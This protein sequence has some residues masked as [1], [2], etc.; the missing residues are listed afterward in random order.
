MADPQHRGT[1]TRL[2]ARNAMTDAQADAAEWRR[3]AADTP[4][5]WIA[6]VCLAKA[7]GCDANA[8]YWQR[9]L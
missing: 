1:G 2:D 6:A 9:R 8:K 4:V 3:L 5:E 7:R